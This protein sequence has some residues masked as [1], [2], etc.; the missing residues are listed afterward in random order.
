MPLLS[1]ACK[2]ACQ[3]LCLG[4]WHSRLALA[5]PRGELGGLH[6]PGSAAG[7]PGDQLPRWE[8]H[9]WDL[10]GQVTGGAT[11]L[12]ARLWGW[13]R[14][15]SES[16]PVTA[17]PPGSRPL[18]RAGHESRRQCFL[19]IAVT[20]PYPKSSGAFPDLHSTRL[21]RCWKHSIPF[22]KSALL[23][24]P[25]H[26]V[27]P[28]P[29]LGQ[30]L[31]PTL[32]PGRSTSVRTS[33]GGLPALVRLRVRKTSPRWDT[34]LCLCAQWR[35]GHAS[36]RQHL[37]RNAIGGRLRDTRWQRQGSI[38]ATMTSTGLGGPGRE[39]VERKRCRAEM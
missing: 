13:A 34:D 7:R 30:H 20:S 36:H 23:E 39:L 24:T 29:Q 4:P 31:G 18:S 3:E 26:C 8:R 10:A 5:L 25:P 21:S 12:Q 19:A 11:A 33:A 14:A 27:V 9:T 15:H 32:C 17:A 37:R 2:R 35:R 28:A 22:A 16:R 1:S 38:R 6:L